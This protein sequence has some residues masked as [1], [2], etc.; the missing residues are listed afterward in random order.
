MCRLF[1]LLGTPVTR[2]E[3]WLLEMDRSLMVQ[4][5]V[6][7]EV[8]QKD[9]WGLAWYDTRR[10]PKIE[11]GIHG[12]FEATE[13]TRFETA[14]RAARGPVVLG[15]LRHASNPMGLPRSRLLALENCQP[16]THEGALFIH[17]GEI[18]LPRETR[19]RLG[20][21]E[22]HV[23]GVNDSEVLFWLFTNHLAAVGDPVAAF[24]KTRKDLEEV[25]KENG[26][27]P[28]QPYSALNVI[29]TRG[30]NELWAFCHWLGDHGGGLLD[31]GRPYFQM[32][33]QSDA[34]SLIVG[35]EPFA[36]KHPEWRPFENNTYLVGHVEHGLVGVKTGTIP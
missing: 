25:W 15:H 13:K 17:N 18:T 31:T 35:S 23:R 27:H 5:H 14:A 20:K 12:A 1:G 11:Q 30:P 8:A 21:F 16:F 9:G 10:A 24:G 26:K 7:E 6:S 22:D 2:A 29:Y 32:G 34:K 36:A 4:S 33:Y 19:P 3:R 28:D